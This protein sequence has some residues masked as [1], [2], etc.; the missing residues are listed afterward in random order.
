VFYLD[1]HEMVTLT[2][3]GSVTSAPSTTAWP[4]FRYKQLH[5]RRV[6]FSSMI[7][8]GRLRALLLKEIF[9]QPQTIRNAV[10]AARVWSGKMGDAHL[11]PV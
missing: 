10:S 3:D 5:A 4:R 11:G 2:D 6:G 7:E 1:D 8:E 9:E